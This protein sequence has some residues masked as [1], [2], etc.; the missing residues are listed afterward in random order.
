MPLECTYN[1][2]AEKNGDD[3]NCAP[4]PDLCTASPS[5]V[6][7]MRQVIQ[8][9]IGGDGE[10]K[11]TRSNNDGRTAQEESDQRLMRSDEN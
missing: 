4:C 6:P 5:L 9:T 8:A 10:S 7:K 11:A 2:R 1:P 3:P